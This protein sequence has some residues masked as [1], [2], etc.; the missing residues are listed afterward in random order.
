MVATV[1]RSNIQLIY[2]S[3]KIMM[4]TITENADFKI[5]KKLMYQCDPRFS[6]KTKLNLDFDII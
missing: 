3:Q 4:K 6:K 1:F 5:A 2:Y